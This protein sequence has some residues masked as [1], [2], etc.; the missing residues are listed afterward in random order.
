M[1]AMA[2]GLMYIR[3]R[4]III[5]ENNHH[6][7]LGTQAD[8]REQVPTAFGARTRWDTAK[9]HFFQINTE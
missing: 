6:G 5:R 4:I 1:Y 2:D 8:R 3:E 9:L 7:K